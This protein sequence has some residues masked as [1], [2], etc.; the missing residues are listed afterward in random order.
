MS[1]K[2][3]LLRRV[4]EATDVDTLYTVLGENKDPFFYEEVLACASADGIAFIVRCMLDLDVD[5]D[6]RNDEPPLY[7][8]TS[9]NHEGVVEALLEYGYVKILKT[10]Y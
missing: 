2:D 10:V 7:L 1:I 6:I 5:V 3:S 8:A 9:Y 4:L